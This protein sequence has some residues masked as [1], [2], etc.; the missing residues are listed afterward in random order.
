MS[1]NFIKKSVRGYIKIDVTIFI[2]CSLFTSLKWK[3]KFVLSFMEVFIKEKGHSHGLWL[4]DCSV[5][6]S[7]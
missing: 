3:A 2:S 6:R 4:V 5:Q 7:D 1:F